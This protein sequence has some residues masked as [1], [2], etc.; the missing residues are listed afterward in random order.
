VYAGVCS[1]EQIGLVVRCRNSYRMIFYED[2]DEI[3]C[4]ISCSRGLG[5]GCGLRV[6]FDE[7][8]TILDRCQRLKGVDAAL[9]VLIGLRRRVCEDLE[10]VLVP[11]IFRSARLTDCEVYEHFM[12]SQCCHCATDCWARRAGFDV[13]LLDEALVAMTVSFCIVVRD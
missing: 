2:V 10:A 5:G 12:T 3:Y 6:T 9:G 7:C 8:L 13:S 11:T 1:C 4:Q